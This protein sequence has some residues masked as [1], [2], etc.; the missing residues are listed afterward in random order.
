MQN[1]PQGMP[2]VP[3]SDIA[4]HAANVFIQG[5]YQTLA[6]LDSLRL[7]LTNKTSTRVIISRL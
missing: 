2:L 7:E 6:F 5:Y 4:T 3:Q 1:Q